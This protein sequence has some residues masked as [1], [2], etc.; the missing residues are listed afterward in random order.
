VR[1]VE[2]AVFPLAGP[3]MLD[4]EE[5]GEGEDDALVLDLDLWSLFLFFLAGAALFEPSS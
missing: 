3:F 1:V 2:E 5:V 4:P